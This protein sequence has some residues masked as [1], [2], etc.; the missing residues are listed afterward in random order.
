MRARTAV[1]NRKQVV[2]GVV[3]QKA[4]ALRAVQALM[5][6]ACKERYIVF[7]HIQSYVTK[8]LR[9]VYKERNIVQ[10]CGFA[11]RINIRQISRNVGDMIDAYQFCVSR[12]GVGDSYGRNYTVF[13]GSYFNE[14]YVH[15][16]F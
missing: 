1:T 7:H 10:L 15:S 9:A 16:I 8:R 13:V 5:S 4:R 12:Y 11:N 2:L 14:I 3:Y 6:C